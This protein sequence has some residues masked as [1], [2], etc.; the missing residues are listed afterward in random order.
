MPRT[1]IGL[2]TYGHMEDLSR[3]LME[4]IEAEHVRPAPRW[5][6]VL[7]R[8]ARWCAAGLVALSAALAMA[9]LVSVVADL[10]W[11]VYFERPGMIRWAGALSLFPYVWVLALM[12]LAA[13]AWHEVRRTDKGY[14]FPG[15][16]LGIMLSLVLVVVG[17]ILFASSAGRYADQLARRNVPGYDRTVLTKEAQW[18]RPDD[19]LLA[20]TIGTVAGNGFSIEDFS[21]KTWEISTDGTTVV[22][23]R[24]AVAPGGEV[25]VVGEREGN[26]GFRADEIRPWDGRRNP[27]GRH[28][29]DTRPG[30]TNGARNGG[31]DDGD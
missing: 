5:R 25:K 4:R 23:P 31:P 12:A 27:D 24:A 1:G 6:F 14:R 11:A 9:V 2:L 21:G 20:G 19:G 28:D 29:P 26:D 13:F 15:A 22:R 17:G 10:D 7:G 8:A 30:R 16:R 18:S 3:K